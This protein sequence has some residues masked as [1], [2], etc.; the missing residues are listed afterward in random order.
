ML[1]DLPPAHR[2]QCGMRASSLRAFASMRRR[3]AG[4]LASY[5]AA[6]LRWM[7]AAIVA[8]HAPQRGLW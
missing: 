2:A 5:S 6:F 8:S 7:A 3:S 4:T 1:H